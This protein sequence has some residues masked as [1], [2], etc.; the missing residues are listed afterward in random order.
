MVFSEPEVSLAKISHGTK[1]PIPFLMHNAGY[2]IQ[3][4][5]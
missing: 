4:T 3:D 5:G 2:T 1:V